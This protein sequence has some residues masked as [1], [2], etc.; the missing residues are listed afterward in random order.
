MSIRLRKDYV[1]LEKDA[2][3]SLAEV[4]THRVNGTEL[5]VGEELD[6]DIIR[7]AENHRHTLNLHIGC[8][9]QKVL[10]ETARDAL[11]PEWRIDCEPDDLH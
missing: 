10:D 9:I 11:P 3:V 6:S 2:V 4:C 1:P 8:L 7:F 5:L